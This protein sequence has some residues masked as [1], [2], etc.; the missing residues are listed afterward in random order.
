MYIFIYLIFFFTEEVHTKKQEMKVAQLHF[1][2]V[3]GSHT[4]LCHYNNLSDHHKKC[5][6]AWV[7]F[8]L[9]ALFLVKLTK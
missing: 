3:C 6:P 9:A 5:I 4:E 2:L 7:V 1:D 8:L